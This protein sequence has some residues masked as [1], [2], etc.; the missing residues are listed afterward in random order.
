VR[1]TAPG[2]VDFLMP[3]PWVNAV[4]VHRLS[5]GRIT[6]A[7]ARLKIGESFTEGVVANFSVAVTSIDRS[8]HTATL[9]FVSCAQAPPTVLLRSV[10]LVE[11]STT[12]PFPF[13]RDQPAPQAVLHLLPRLSRT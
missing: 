6:R 5:K 12:S 11:V 7:L 10:V 13:H 1:T 3:E 9:S 2:T 4:Y 8:A